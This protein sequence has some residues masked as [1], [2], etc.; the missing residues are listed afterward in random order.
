[1]DGQTVREGRAGSEGG[2]VADGEGEVGRLRGGAARGRGDTQEVAALERRRPME[3]KNCTRLFFFAMYQR[4]A[5]KLK[6]WLW[7]RA[8][9]AVNRRQQQGREVREEGGSSWSNKL[10]GGR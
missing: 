5:Q 4:S 3:K 1:M 7:L 10:G 9:E 2:M 8:G 6:T